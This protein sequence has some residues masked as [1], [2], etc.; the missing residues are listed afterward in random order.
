MTNINYNSI[1]VDGSCCPN[2]GDMEYRGVD[3]TTN[4]ELFRVGPIPHGTSNIAEYIAIVDALKILKESGDND[5]VIYSDSVTAIRWV[6]DKRPNTAIKYGKDTKEVF[7]LLNEATAWLKSNKIKNNIF[8][9]GTYHWGE[10]PAD[11]GRKK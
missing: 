8:K 7:R 3:L 11:F 5:K 4:Q 6:K 1:A 2:P 9:W 10:N